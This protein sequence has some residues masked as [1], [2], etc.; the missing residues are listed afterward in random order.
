MVKII[1]DIGYCQGVQKAIDKLLNCSKMGKKVY[2]T[3]PLL[4]NLKENEKLMEESHATF[5]NKELTIQ[6]GYLV[7]S[8]HGHPLEEEDFIQD[9]SYIVDATCPLI[10]NRYQLLKEEKEDTTYLFVGKEN[11]QETLGFLSHF[12]F[13]TF[14]DSQKDLKTQLDAI[15]LKKNVFF[16]PQTTISQ[17]CV[18]FVRDYLTQ[19]EVNI[20]SFLGICPLYE[21][22]MKDASSYCEHLDQS[23]SFFIVCGDTLSSNAQELYHAIKEKNPSLQGAISLSIAN[24]DTSLLKG[25]DIYITSATSASKETVEKLYEDCLHLQA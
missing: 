9:K 3:H 1:S 24:M 15:P 13:L 11:H 8:A 10:L 17:K 2:L 22:R 21:K 5:V 4:H 12:P 6:D 20:V 14:V 7:L 19:K 25:K 23:N 16:L 18:N